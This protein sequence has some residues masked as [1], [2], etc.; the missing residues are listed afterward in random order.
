MYFDPGYTAYG[1]HER[2][3]ELLDK[4]HRGL[5]LDAPSGTG[6]LSHLLKEKGFDVIAG[7]INEDVVQTENIRFKK[8]DL[9][10]NL[11]F[12]DS[13][14]DFVVN[15]EG[16]EHLENPHHVI[17]E[18]SRVLK[19]QGKLIITTPNIL[20]IFSRLRYFL[21]GYHEYF[22]DYYSN[23]DNFY[24]LHINPVGF[25]EID[26]ALRKNGF[27]IEEITLNQDVRKVRGL[28]LRIFLNICGSITKA[29]T[30][31]KVQDD[32]IKDY[33]LSKPLIFGEILIIKCCKRAKN[34]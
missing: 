7:D 24:V 28:L 5:L 15:V 10:Q 13:S 18:F 20:N 1:L 8:I 30:K 16:L 12:D 11:P 31:W 4:E 3:L 25:P 2:T 33:L 34:N 23:E 14:L 9:N 21:I 17:R 32:R 19:L 26:F 27:V 22:G 29:A 6:R